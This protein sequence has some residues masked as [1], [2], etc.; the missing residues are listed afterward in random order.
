MRRGGVATLTVLTSEE[1]KPHSAEHTLRFLEAE[2]VEKDDDAPHYTWSNI[3]TA[4]RQPKV[5]LYAWVDSFTLLTLRYG[6]TVK[7]ISSNRQIKINRTVSRQITD[8]EKLIIATINTAYSS[9]VLNTGKYFFADLS[10]V[11]LMCAFILNSNISS[12]SF[13]N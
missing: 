2:Y 4:T 7:K 3:L 6:E 5:A 1:Q 12:I 10:Q 8:D 13:K 11:L 9:V